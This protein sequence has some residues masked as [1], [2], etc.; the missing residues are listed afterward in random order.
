[1][2]ESLCYETE[3][4]AGWLAVLLPGRLPFTFWSWPLLLCA[5]GGTVYT[6][7]SVLYTHASVQYTPTSVY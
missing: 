2:I 7:A 4:W 5:A 3:P 6:H 1:M